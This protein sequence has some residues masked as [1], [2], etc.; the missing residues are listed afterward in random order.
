MA[1]GVIFH[2]RADDNILTR[3]NPNAKLLSL[4]VFSAA[5]SSV[6]DALVFILAFLVLL[7][8]FLI[9]LPFGAYIRESFLFIILAVCMSVTAYLSTEQ[10]SAA[11][12]SGIGFLAMV[13]ASMLLT[14]TT[15]PDDMARSLGA[16]LSHVI[17]RRAYVI[18]TVVE[19]TVSMIPLIVDS[20]VTMYEARRSRSSSFV[21]H[22]MRSISEFAV[23][24]ISDLLDKAEE[25]TDALYARGYDAAKRRDVPSYRTSDVIVIISDVIITTILILSA[26]N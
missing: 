7:L 22:P 20:T 4:L 14:D 17:G 25:Y 8:A 5:V 12:A 15:M 2:Y 6:C 21:S 1:E 24:V 19:V 16:A 23:S 9:K 26:V 13:L 11:A 18:A 3:M 10:V